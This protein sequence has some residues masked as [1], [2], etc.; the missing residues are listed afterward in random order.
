MAVVERAGPDARAT[1]T[2]DRPPRS[3]GSAVLDLLAAGF[4]LV[5]LLAPAEPVR[6][7]VVDLARVPVEALAAGA[8]VL[9]LPRRWAGPVGVAF[10]LLVGLVAVV[11][12]VGW[13]FALGIGR[14]FDPV[15]DWPLLRNGLDYVADALGAAGAVAVLTALAVAA[16]ALVVLTA[17][18]SR[19]SAR[20]LRAHRRAGSVTLAALSAVWLVAAAAGSTVA[21]R[22]TAAYVVDGT[23]QAAHSLADLRSFREGLADDPL[24][25]RSAGG[26]LA[27]LRG[28]NVLVVFV[29]SYGRSALTDPGLAPVVEPVARAGGERLRAAGIAAASGWLTSPT[30]GGGSWLAH[31][32]LYAGVP[33]TS[34]ARYDALLDSD[35]TNLVRLF[36]DAG[37][38]TTT[39]LPGTTRPWPEGAAYYGFDSVHDRED[40]GYQGAGFGWGQVPDQF[41]LAALQR[42]ELAHASAAEPVMASVEL[43]S[44]HAPWT[45]VPGRLLNWSTAGDG[46]AYDALPRTGPDQSLVWRDPATARSAYAGSVAYALEALVSFLTTYGDGRTLTVVL[47]DHQ[48]APLVTGPARSH[49]VPVSVVGPPDLVARASVAWGWADG[50]VPAVGSPA[51]PMQDF[52]DRFVSTLGDAR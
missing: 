33:V 8:L 11:R 5:V 31:S 27:G 3:S 1:D 17:R 7:G 25:G 42:L 23:R 43:V 14:R 37:W 41:T 13:G 40:L 44:S 35:R 26:A 49:D 51:W 15:A 32:T 10:G 22:E 39:L 52:R 24:A 19:R 18:A 30:Y 12:A 21:A 47:G 29:E 9:A 36:H 34:Q 20:L 28:V 4:V 48:P 6:P 16:V 45:P 50:M 46:A 2:A 38:R